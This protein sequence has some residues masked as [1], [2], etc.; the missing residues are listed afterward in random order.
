M[1]FPEMPV[2]LCKSSTQKTENASLSNQVTEYLPNFLGI[3]ILF[4]ECEKMTYFFGPAAAFPMQLFNRCHFCPGS[5]FVFVV[6]YCP[7]A[8]N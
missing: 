1:F 3:M 7:G 8:D 2:M 5:F 6:K 4:G